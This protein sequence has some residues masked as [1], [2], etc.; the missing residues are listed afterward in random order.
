MATTNFIDG[1]TAIVAAWLNDVN[2][3]VY[4]T[5]VTLTGVQVLTNKT[6]TSPVLNTPTVATPTFT[7]SFVGNLTSASP[8]TG[9]GY[10]TG[11]GGVVT[12]LTSKSTGVTL[13]TMCG[14]V[15]MNNAALAN[16]AIVSFTVTNS[17]V[18]ATDNVFASISAGGTVGAYRVV[19]SAIA[20][21][22]FSVSI[23][24]DSG[25]SLSEAPVI[26]FTVFR[27]AIA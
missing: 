27:G 15:T 2:A 24:N 6:L 26:R 21:G 11:S 16:S 20:A 10:A 12:Q 25:G 9:V 19:V 17:S 1:T 8:V 4:N 18:L 22:S 14:N 3:F 13:N 5:G 23:R 7:G